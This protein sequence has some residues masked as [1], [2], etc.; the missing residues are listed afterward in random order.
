M[1]KLN[2]KYLGLDIKSPIIVSSCG[3]T[4]SVDKIKDIETAGAG[5]VVLKSLFEEQIKGQALEL[6]HHVGYHGYPEA[7]DYVNAYVEANHLDDYLNLIKNAKKEVKIPVIASVNCISE[8]GWFD[9]AKKIEQA[10]ADALEV[11]IFMLPNDS[12]ISSDKYEELYLDVARRLSKDLKIP[13][14][15]KIGFYFTNILGFCEKL[16][17]AGAKGVVMFNRFFE[18]DIDINK[19]EIVSAD[20]LSF[21]SEIRK[22]L[23][24]IGIVSDKDKDFDIAS[25]TG[26]H[27]SE[28]AIKMILVGAQAVQVCSAI[29]QEGLGIIEDINNGISAWMDDKGFSKIEDLR[30][31]MNYSN[32]PDAQMFE[33]SQF[34]KYYSNAMEVQY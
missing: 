15:F 23:R 22:S 1:A 24:W 4:D 7:Y 33:R 16:Y 12:S 2:T 5:A 14:S 13:V 6:D 21:P 9:F 30:Y 3:L 25:S 20:R 28:A 18:P 29:Y 11:N 31:K 32:I 27:D 19:M 34:M 10:G 17:A 26:I 8:D